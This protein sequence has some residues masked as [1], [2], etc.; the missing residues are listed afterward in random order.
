MFTICWSEFDGS[1]CGGAREREPACAAGVTTRLESPKKMLSKT[2]WYLTCVYNFFLSV[3]EER[4]RRRSGTRASLRRRCDGIANKF[5]F[6]HF[7]TVRKSDRFCM[8]SFGCPRRKPDVPS[9]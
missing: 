9:T 1:A 7:S 8:R 3:I 2:Q 6:Q 5:V 4:M